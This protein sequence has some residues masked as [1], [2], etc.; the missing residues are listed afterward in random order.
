[1]CHHLAP[2]AASAISLYYGIVYLHGTH[3]WYF[4]F[5]LQGQNILFIPNH[6]YLHPK[7]NLLL[8][9]DQAFKFDIKLVR[10]AP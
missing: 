3:T 4:V 2:L 9:Y 5:F 6:V 1:M 7:P 10:K 8:N